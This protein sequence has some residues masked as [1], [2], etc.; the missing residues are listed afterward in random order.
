MPS[1]TAGVLSIKTIL[2]GFRETEKQ[3]EGKKRMKKV[4]RVST[5]SF[6]GRLES[7]RVNGPSLQAFIQYSS[8]HTRKGRSF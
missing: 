7:E 4:G 5:G 8:N 2:D 3:K 1:T 6:S